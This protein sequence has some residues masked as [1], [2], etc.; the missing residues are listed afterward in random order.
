MSEPAE[1]VVVGLSVLEAGWTTHRERTVI[2]GGRRAAV[3]FPALV[4]VIEHP[5]H[6]VILFD[7]GYSPRVREAMAGFPNALY[8]ALLPIHVAPERTVAAQLAAR[9]VAA[10]AVTHVVLSHFHA[11]HIGAAA[12]FPQARYVFLEAGYE[13]VAR[14]GA[15]G[16][17]LAGFLPALLPDDFEARARCLTASDAAP[18]LPGFATAYD[19]FGD[20]SL[21][22]VELPGHACGQLGLVCRTAQGERF[23]VADACTM[24]GNALEARRPSAILR[25]IVDD[26]GQY[27]DTMDR[28]RDLAEARP[29][30]PLIPSHCGEAYLRHV[31][32]A[33]SELGGAPL[34]RSRPQ[35]R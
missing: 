16:R 9:G 23:F 19:L 8:K 30:L 32:D 22:L 5:V 21:R 27:L 11:D 15:W 29:D 24:L 3:A 7:T 1:Q 26:W 10:E 34:N 4:A 33:A 17:L 12:C 18:P 14:R 6:G 25:L 35:S 13:A 2:A 20:G 28:L 31:T